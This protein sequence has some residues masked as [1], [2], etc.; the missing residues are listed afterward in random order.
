V[1]INA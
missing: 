1:L